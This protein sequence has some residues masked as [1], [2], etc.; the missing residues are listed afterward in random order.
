[1]YE[2]NL[3][4]HTVTCLQDVMSRILLELSLATLTDTLV[5]YHSTY[6]FRPAVQRIVVRLHIRNGV[7]RIVVGLHIGKGLIS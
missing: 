3:D 5:R 7:L 1:M 2:I 6:V 4:K